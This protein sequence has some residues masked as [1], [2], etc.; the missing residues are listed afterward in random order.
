MEK[1]EQKEIEEFYNY[2]VPTPPPQFNV[3]TFLHKV[4]TTE[5]TTKVGFLSE[6]ELGT[7]SLNI[8]GLKEM[9][10]VSKFICQNELLSEWFRKS[11]ED[12][13]ATSLSRHAKLLTTGITQKRT[14]EDETKII[15]PNK[16]WF[17]PKNKQEEEQ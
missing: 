10:R 6:E 3:H 13:L 15:K 7:P 8:R 11:A 2:P 1:E 5:D 14:I 9:E 16:G 4:L 12:I 17:K